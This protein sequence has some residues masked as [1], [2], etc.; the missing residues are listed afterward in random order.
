M[1]GWL[2]V[3]DGFF[4]IFTSFRARHSSGFLLNLCVGVLF[5][6][7]GVMIIGNPLAS[8]AVLTL[9]LAALF[10]AGGLFRIISASR[11]QYRSWGWAVLEGV[12]TVLA[13]AMIWRAWPSSALWVL[14][15][16]L[17]IVLLF[18]GL[19]WMMFAMA[20]RELPSYSED[21]IQTDE[22]YR[23]AA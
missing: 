23:P 19:S 3:F 9:V 4:E 21:R 2:L 18:R 13:G 5:A 16:F 12:I 1:F 10:L 22:R 8:A 14:G 11:L 20:S 6:V 15:T 17:G 7:G